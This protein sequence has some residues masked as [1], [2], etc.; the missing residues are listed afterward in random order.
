M[1]AIILFSVFAALTAVAGTIVVGINTFDGTVTDHPYERGLEW[2]KLEQKKSEL[3]W[4]CTIHNSFFKQG[5]N[6]LLFTLKNKD[7]QPLDASKIEIKI[8]RP[9]TDTHDKLYAVQNRGSGMYASEAYFPLIG[10]WDLLF[11][12]TK[13]SDHITIHKNIYIKKEEDV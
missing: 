11:S 8:T 3:G 9:S 5:K 1:K 7:G 12:V 13:G 4:T 10:H 6:N 2:E